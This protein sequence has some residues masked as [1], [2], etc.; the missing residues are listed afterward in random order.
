MKSP[1]M[2]KTFRKVLIANRGEIA[3]RVVRACRE[4]NIKTVAIFSDADRESLHVILS[5]EAY[6]IGPAPSKESYLNIKKIIHGLPPSLLLLPAL[7][8][9]KRPLM[10]R[11]SLIFLQR[12]RSIGNRK[13]HPY[14]RPYPNWRHRSLNNRP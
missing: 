1:N 6:N 12:S 9:P 2:K 8:F 11:T 5:D 7:S 4:L 3:I 14:D 13:F 10:Q